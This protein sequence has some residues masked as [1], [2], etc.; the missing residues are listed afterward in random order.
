MGVKREK[1]IEAAEAVRYYDAL[2]EFDIGDFTMRVMIDTRDSA[3]D[4]SHIS[5]QLA[6]PHTRLQEI[7]NQVY[8]RILS[9]MVALKQD[10]LHMLREALADEYDLELG[11][12]EG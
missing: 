7:K 2:R 9:G 1:A 11:D 4:E 12:E 6:H 3:G 10:A 5:L 8:S